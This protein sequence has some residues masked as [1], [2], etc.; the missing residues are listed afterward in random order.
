MLNSFQRVPPAINA[1]VARPGLALEDH[2]N[3]LLV[4]SIACSSSY[5]LHFMQIIHLVSTIA[6]TVSHV[7][8]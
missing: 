3:F 8:L 4:S 6:Q 2:D 5:F 7:K 1:S